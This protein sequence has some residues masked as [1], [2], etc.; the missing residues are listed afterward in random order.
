MKTLRIIPALVLAVAAAATAAPTGASPERSLSLDEAL[1]LALARNENLVVVREAAAAAVAAEQGA[2]GA[3]DPLLTVDGGWQRTKQPVNSAF[4]GAP[5]GEDAPTTRGVTGD[6]TLDQHLPT[7]GDLSLNVTST[8]Y[9]TDSSFELLSPAYQTDAGLTLRQPL[10]RGRGVD[11]A[12]LAIRVARADRTRTGADLVRETSDTVA[13]VATAYYRLDAAEAQVSVR[14]DAVHLA[15]EQLAQ[16]Q[17]RVTSGAVPETEEA[18][19]RAEVERRR[20]ELFAAQESLARAGTALK[21]LVLGADDDLWSATLR[22]QVSD[23]VDLD[24]VDVDSAMSLALRSRPE[25]V[26]ADAAIAREDARRDYAHDSTHPRLDA[27]VGYTRFGLTGTANPAASDGSG[28]PAAVPPSFAGD[29]GRS[30]RMLTNSSFDDL[31]AGL[32]F[33]VPLGNTTAQ[34]DLAVA[35]HQVRQAAAD[36]TRARKSIRAEVLDAAA[37]LTTAQQR[38]AA[39]RAGREAAEVQLAAEQDRYGAGMST[40]FLVLT[41]QNDLAAARLEE[42]AAATDYRIARTEVQRATGTLLARHHITVDEPTR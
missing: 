37:A 18:Q 31:S 19:P 9:T 26:A 6:V 23:A 4:S 10:W 29:W 28:A 20:G 36:F 21:L 40:N 16:T 32:V 5:V 2:H 11:P 34:G 41:R 1:Q 22:P 8:R 33:S 13:A 35:R 7:G 39:A 24:P 12:R 17:E 14:E 42:I 25:L 38:M 3:Y 15:Q 30:W 27:V